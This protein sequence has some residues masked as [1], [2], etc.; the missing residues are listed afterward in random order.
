VKE[1]IKRWLVDDQMWQL[2]AY[3]WR[4]HARVSNYLAA[5]PIKALNIGTGG[6]AETLALLRRGNHVTTIEISEETAERTRERIV[7]TGFGDMH[8]G[9]VGH[10]LEL[11]LDDTFHQVMMCEVLEHIADDYAALERIAGWL[12]PGGRLIMSTP[13]NIHGQLPG[14]ELSAV[15][16]GGHVRVGYEGPEL[17]E[18]LQ[19]V[20]LITIH[21]EYNGYALTQ[22]YLRAERKLRANAKTRLFGYGVSVAA[23][24]L[25]RLMEQVKVQPSDQIT[26]AIKSGVP[27]VK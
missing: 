23:R 4:R 9:L 13:T 18:M 3:T 8:T 1:R 17:D 6:G 20:G 14:D 16:D 27:S 10:V 2:D 25:V 7:R 15:E 12:E 11:D 26:V 22:Q 19:A 24:P 21:R 5:G